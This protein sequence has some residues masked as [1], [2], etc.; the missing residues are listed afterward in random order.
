MGLSLSRSAPSMALEDAEQPAAACWIRLPEGDGP[1]SPW[2]TIGTRPGSILRYTSVTSP[3]ARPIARPGRIGTV[4]TACLGASARRRVRPC[5]GSPP[6]DGDSPHDFLHESARISH[7]SPCTVLTPPCPWAIAVCLP[8]D[9][10]RNVEGNPD[11]SIKSCMLRGCTGY[12]LYMY[13]H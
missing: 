12:T 4:P 9:R 2:A 11:F 13:R 1:A 10:F 5:R 8:S 6:P 3:R 7:H